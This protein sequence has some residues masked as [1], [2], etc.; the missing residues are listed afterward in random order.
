MPLKRTPP[1]ISAPAAASTSNT[2]IS[3]LAME[4]APCTPISAV[5]EAGLLSRSGFGLQQKHDSSPDLRTHDEDFNNLTMRF[6]RKQAFCEDS[7]SSIMETV[8]EQMRAMFVT[9]SRDQANRFAELQSSVS[10]IENQNTTITQSVQFIS[11]QYDEL[12][13]Q[14]KASEMDR[15]KDKLR[16]RELEDKIESLERKI[17][18]PTVEIRNLPLQFTSDTKYDKK[19]ELFR[20]MKSLG[21]TIGVNIAEKDIKDIY[22]KKTHNNTQKVVVTEFTSI[23]QKEKIIEAVRIFN[24]GKKNTEKLSSVHVGL[25]TMNLPIYVCE[26]LTQR[27]QKLLFE[28]R[29]VAKDK[30]YVHCCTSR[31][32]VFIKKTEKSK[33]IK[34]NN[35]EDLANIRN[36]D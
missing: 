34:I 8:L 15:S 24:K 6:K 21:E 11:D 33:Y 12:L 18:E 35:E 16:I 25:K 19:E 13:E 20:M 1:Q 36:S 2:A 28:A 17:R 5:G 4:T 26:A 10:K 22:S 30:G 9:F 27:T 29:K 14:L 3:S 32:Y 7:S 23:I 31:G